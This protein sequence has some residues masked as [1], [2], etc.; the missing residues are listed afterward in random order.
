MRDGY[1]DV[2]KAHVIGI[3]P[4][5]CDDPECTLLYI[6]LA[7]EVEPIAY[8]TISIAHIEEDIEKAKATRIELLKRPI[9]GYTV[10]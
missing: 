6:E 8:G 1:E 4:C 5:T 2:K 7:D 9:V 3:G 10:H